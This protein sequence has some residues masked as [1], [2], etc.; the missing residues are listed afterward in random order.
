MLSNDKAIAPHNLSAPYDATLYL[1]IAIALVSWSKKFNIT[2][3]VI[4]VK[5]FIDED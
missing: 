1:E 3:Q 5:H 4:W 2:L